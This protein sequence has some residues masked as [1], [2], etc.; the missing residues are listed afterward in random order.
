MNNQEK[1]VAIRVIAFIIF[2]LSVFMA[3]GGPRS[4]FNPEWRTLGKILIV[5][6]IVMWIRAEI[7]L[8]PESEIKVKRD[9]KKKRELMVMP[10]R[11]ETEPE[12]EIFPVNVSRIGKNQASISF[13]DLSTISSGR[14]ENPINIIAREN[15]GRAAD[16]IEKA[17]NAELSAKMDKESKEKIVEIFKNHPDVSKIR[18]VA[19][20]EKGIFSLPERR[21]IYIVELGKDGQIHF[22]HKP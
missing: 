9:N 15:P 6:I 8:A 16:L 20:R 4:S 12:N 18:L 17:I 19:L 22:E 10:R 7:N 14:E 21:D 11:Y 1:L 5:I 13:P 2:G 3:M